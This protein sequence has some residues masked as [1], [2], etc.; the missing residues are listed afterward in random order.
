MIQLLENVPGKKISIL[1]L[2]LICFILFANP[3]M[4]G[5][6]TITASG[7]QS[8]YRGEEITFSG[9]N[10][11]TETTYLFVMSPNL[12]NNG[13]Q[14][15]APGTN[16]INKNPD[17]FVKVAVAG[18]NTWSYTWET[19]S[20]P[21][22]AGT[23]TVYAVSNPSDR[24]NLA[25]VLYGT[26]SII[27]KRP[28]IDAI[29][30]QNGDEFDIT[31]SAEGCPSHGV[32]IWIIGENYVEMK[33]VP[34]GRDCSFQ[35]TI[36]RE[37]TLNL[38]NGNYFILLQHPMQNDQL[39]IVRSDINPDYVRNVQIGASGGTDLFPLFGPKSLKGSEAANALV[40]ALNDPSV[41]DTYMDFYGSV[42]RPIKTQVTPLST[43]TTISQPS[44]TRDDNAGSSIISIM[45]DSGYFLAGIL[46]L[47]II[48]GVV[49]M[50]Y[51]RSGK[52]NGVKQGQSIL[53]ESVQRVCIRCGNN[54]DTSSRYCTVCGNLLDTNPAAGIKPDIGHDSLDE[55]F[56]GKNM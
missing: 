28:F 56:Q 55:G 27:I 39:D 2:F 44:V 36:P 22:G 12:N 21:L 19:A 11:E 46:V 8:Y 45:K 41:D 20:I 1:S 10:T 30:Y 4:A 49:V 25:G 52:K 15:I 24:N 18:D 48:T 51:R 29:M 54:V 37:T 14:L 5:Q 26:V 50:Q 53:A 13:A 16:V 42:T 7:D 38:V 43:Q 34:V 40:Q 35:F 3:V 33:T 47:V 17:T 6:V 9:T 32:Q 31:G 23:Y